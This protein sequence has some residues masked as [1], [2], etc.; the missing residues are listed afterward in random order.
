MELGLGLVQCGYEIYFIIYCL[1][2]CLVYFYE[3]VYYYEVG[4]EDYLL[5]EYI[6]YDIVLV[7]KLVDVVKYENF[8]LFYVYYVILYVVV[9]YMVKKILFIEGCYVLVVIILYGIDI[10][11]VGNNKVFLFVV[12]FLINKLDGVMVVLE[13]LCW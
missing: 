4:V 13:S 1:F 12:V 3:N 6:F 2:V 5:F 7:S 10:I 9:V 11:F 8:D